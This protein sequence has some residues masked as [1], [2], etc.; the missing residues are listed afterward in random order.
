LIY[1]IPVGYL[2]YKNIVFVITVGLT[3]GIAMHLTRMMMND[4]N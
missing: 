4:K 1:E 2:P 3:L